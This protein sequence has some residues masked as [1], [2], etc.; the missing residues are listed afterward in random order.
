MKCRSLQ[1]AGILVATIVLAGFSGAPLLRG[2]ASFLIVE[3]PLE[4]AAAIVSLGGQLPF[5]ELEAAELYRAG[6]APKVIIVRTLPSPEVEALK[7][8]KVKKPQDWELSSEVLQ[9]QGVPASAIV[10]PKDEGIGTLEELQAVWRT[11]AKHVG[12]QGAWSREQGARDQRTDHFEF[13]N[14]DFGFINASQPPSFPGSQQHPR[15]EEQRAG[16]LSPVS[17]R[18]PNAVHATNAM[19]VILVTSKYHTR[20]TR[21]TWQ[22]VSAGRSQPIVRAASGDPFEPENWWQTRRYALSVVREYLGLAN[23]YAGFAVSP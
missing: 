14:A 10:I 3:D 17:G 22:Y 19:P 13:R 2:V 4:R 12:E 6:W 7:A 20:R 21:L 15:G 16:P 8:L 23:Y 1:Y 9:Q 18:V 11:L 5:R